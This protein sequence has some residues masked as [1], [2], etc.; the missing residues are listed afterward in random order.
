[1]PLQNHNNEY[2]IG[3]CEKNVMKYRIFFLFLLLV[4]LFNSQQALATNQILITK[5]FTMDKIIFDGKWSFYTEWKQSSLNTLSYGDG[6]VLQLRTAHQGDFLYVFVD[7]VY[8]TNWNKGSDKAVVCIDGNDDRNLAADTSD[9]CFVSVLE[10]KQSFVLQGGSPIGFTNNFEKIP[11]PDGFIGIGSV[12]DK[13]DRYTSVSH[14]SYEFRIPIELFGRSG[15]Y[16]FYVG[17]YHSQ[18]NK[19]YSWPQ[20]LNL[21]TSLQIPS[22]DKWGELISPD[23]SLPEFQW[24][25]IPLVVAVIFSIYLARTKMSLLYSH[26]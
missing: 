16:G 26:R 19:I 2:L 23:K 10:G 7:D 9:Y 11:I 12:S 22:P 13:N 17:V 21:N 4:T 6:T 25:F 20:E 8:A 14:P 5:S 18:S 15:V 24:A 3:R 1:M